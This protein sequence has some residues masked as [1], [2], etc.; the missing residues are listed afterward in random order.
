MILE[1]IVNPIMVAAGVLTMS[2]GIPLACS[3]GDL[4]IVQMKGITDSG[5]FV[6][7]AS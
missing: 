3:F 6:V 4:M 7:V 1:S 5:L 2:L